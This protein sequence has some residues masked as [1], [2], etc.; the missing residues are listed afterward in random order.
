MAAAACGIP[1]IGKSDWQNFVETG[2]Q[3]K[4]LV[5]HR[6]TLKE[7]ISLRSESDLDRC[8]LAKNFLCHLVQ[9]GQGQWCMEFA[10]K[11]VAAPKPAPKR[12]HRGRPKASK[13]I[14]LEIG[15]GRSRS[16]LWALFQRLRSVDRDGEPSLMHSKLR[17]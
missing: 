9:L 13:I 16:L 4:G 17:G 6:R 7:K 1:V 3:L 8:D 15:D 2:G 5:G 11:K 10:G 12:R 14:D